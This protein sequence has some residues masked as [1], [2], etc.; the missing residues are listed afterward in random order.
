MGEARKMR[1]SRRIRSGQGEGAERGGGLLWAWPGKVKE[2]VGL[3]W[4]R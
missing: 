1:K 4:I 3:A 2:E